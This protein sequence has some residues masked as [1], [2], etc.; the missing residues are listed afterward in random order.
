M[1]SSG[2]TSVGGKTRPAFSKMAIAVERTG[3]KTVTTG[4][5]AGQIS[6]TTGK[7]TAP[8]VIADA[9]QVWRS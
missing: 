5:T 8:I 4:M 7:T 1:P 2:G 6:P 9:D 3:V